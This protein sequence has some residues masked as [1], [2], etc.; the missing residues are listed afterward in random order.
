[1]GVGGERVKA[2]AIL[3]ALVLLA[4]L[5]VMA[6]G[7]YWKISPDSVSYVSAAV[8]LASGQGYTEAGK[9]VILFPPVTSLMFCIPVMLF[10]GSYLALNALVAALALLAHAAAFVLLRK[11]VS[12]VRAAVCVLLS[13]ASTLIFHNSTLLLSD[14]PYFFWSV[15][16]LAVAEHLSERQSTRAQ[17]LILA[18]IVWI[19]CM[20]RIAGVTLVAAIAAYSLISPQRKGARRNLLVLMLLVALTIALWEARSLH[21][22]TSYLKLTLQN[23]PWVDEAG[24]ASPLGLLR[25]FYHNLDDYGA[26]GDILTDGIFPARWTFIRLLARGM[27][28]G[29]FFLGLAYSMRRRITVTSIYC[30]IYLLVCGAYFTYID[31]RFFVPIMPLLFH[32]EL[33]GGHAIL[34]QARLRLRGLAP[35]IARVGLAVYVA[36]FVCTG[37]A[38]MLRAVPGEHSSPFGACPIKYVQNYDLQ[39]LALWLRDN[40]AADETY[41]CQHADLVGYITE[42]EGYNFPFSADPDKVVDALEGKQVTYVLADKKKEMVQQF[43]LP[44]IKAYP[45][46]FTLIQ[47]EEDASLYEF[48]LQP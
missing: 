20:T 24:Y 14:V 40:S 26:I 42:R 22:G 19:A 9:P 38:R 33:V 31:V 36:C 18:V 32:Y 16:A 23:E 6:I 12:S 1:M 17:Q 15:V 27:A 21:L 29:L 5:Y 41:V 7:P 47:E 35:T 25:K 13:L 44:A 48:K 45:D 28:L 46:R 2:V 39:R 37:T 30:A 10:P 43:L 8:S 3:L 4:V 11:K 34:A